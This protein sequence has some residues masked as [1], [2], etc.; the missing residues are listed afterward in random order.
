MTSHIILCDLKW[1]LSVCLINLASFSRRTFLS[2]LRQVPVYSSADL[3]LR[4][5]SLPFLYC[6]CNIQ[7]FVL[8]NSSLCLHFYNISNRLADQGMSTGDSF[9]IFPSRLLAS[10]EPTNLNSISSSNVMSYAFTVHPTLILSKSTSSSTTTSAFLRIASS[11]SIR[12]SISRCSSFA[13]S[14]SAIL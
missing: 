10:V 4:F 12:A 5:S 6:T 3:P 8:H 14:Y 7:Y 1:I 11:S 2:Y 9:E 13:A